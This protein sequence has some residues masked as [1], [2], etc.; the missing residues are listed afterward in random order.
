MISVRLVRDLADAQRMRV[1]RNECRLFLTGDQREL[2]EADQEQFYYNQIFG[3]KLWAALICHGDDAI[4][5]CSVRADDLGVAGWVTAGVAEARRGESFG[6]M[7]ICKAT[8][9]AVD[10]YGKARVEIFDS[11]KASLHACYKLGYRHLWEVIREPNAKPVKLQV[12]E[13]S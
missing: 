8:N 4:A 12:L 6:T 5:Y 2:T 1:I 7:A 3:G 13:F 10:I 9:A 11:N